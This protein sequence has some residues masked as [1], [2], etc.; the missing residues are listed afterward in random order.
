MKKSSIMK[1]TTCVGVAAAALAAIVYSHNRPPA[2]ARLVKAPSAHFE[3][4]PQAHAEA[5]FPEMVASKRT[6]SIESIFGA[7]ELDYRDDWC[8]HLQLKDDAGYEATPE[9]EAYLQALGYR[10]NNDIMAYK[11]YGRDNL[12]KMGQAGDLIALLTIIAL[13]EDKGLQEWAANEALLYGVTGKAT[14]YLVGQ[15]MGIATNHL[16]WGRDVKAKEK[17]MEAMII[18]RYA[19]NKG[20]VGPFDAT[21]DPLQNGEEFNRLLKP[22]DYREIV[23]RAE[24]LEAELE[25]TRQSRGI[26]ARIVE[27]PKIMKRLA[28]LS[29]ASV[30][31]HSALPAELL[32]Q[33]SFYNP[34]SD[35]IKK[36]REYV[37]AMNN[38]SAGVTIANTR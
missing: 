34:E 32:L 36:N 15:A 18:S 35:C 2:E 7:I 12:I 1:I 8:N 3:Q 16:R 20:D 28:E 23:R 27:V 22:E 17:I 29:I 24:A 9:Q 26:Q 10:N 14:T 11:E 31:E 30:L 33:G 38:H 21:A 37:K 19:L 5:E 13:E 4:P 6:E 25:A